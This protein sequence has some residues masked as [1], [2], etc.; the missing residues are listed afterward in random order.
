MM[1]LRLFAVVRLAFAASLAVSSLDADPA[2]SAVVFNEVH[3]HPA[4][5]I[6]HSE[7]IE[8]RSLN[9]VRVDISKWRIEGGVD[10]DFPEGTIIDGRAFLV[11]AAM[12]AA[13]NLAGA[14]ALGPWIGRLDNGARKSGW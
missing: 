3:Y 14:A 2:D 13:P 5:E 9:G 6:A 4:D 8:L 1:S 12:P 7:Y 11:V 10:Y